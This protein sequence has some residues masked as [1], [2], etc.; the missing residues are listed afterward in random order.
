MDFGEVITMTKEGYTHIIVPTQ[1]HGQLKT[2]AQQK[3]ISIA[4]LITQLVNINVNVNVSVNTGI[5][6]AYLN[7]QLLSPLQALNQQNKLKPTPVLKTE[8]PQSSEQQS[9]Y[10]T[11][12]VNT[13][14]KQHGPG[15]PRARAMREIR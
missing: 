9:N 1:L 10:I 2:L 13:S 3:G 5:N 4:Q 12:C 15:S 8:Y 7:Q 6:T 11:G 14:E